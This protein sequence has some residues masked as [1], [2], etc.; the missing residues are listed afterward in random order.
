MVQRDQFPEDVM[1]IELWKLHLDAL[2]SANYVDAMLDSDGNNIDYLNTVGHGIQPDGDIFQER[3]DGFVDAYTGQLAIDEE[4]TVTD[5]FIDSDGWGTIEVFVSADNPSAIEGL[6]V[7]Y[8]DDAQGAQTVQG[9]ELRTFSGDD[10]DEGFDVF[11]FDTELDG[12]RVRYQNNGLEVSNATIN[13]SMRTQVSFESASFVDKNSLGDQYVR[14]GTKSASDGVKIGAPTSL[15]GDLETIERRTLIDQS[16]SF[17]TSTMRDESES[18]GSGTIAGNPNDSGEIE[19]STGATADSTINLRT[20]A[21]GRYTPG[22]SAQAGMG[23]RLI[24]T[25]WNEG[26]ATWGYFGD[27][28]DNGSGFQFGYDPVEDSLFIA[29]L[30]NGVEVER[31][32]RSNWNGQ[33]FE[34]VYDKPLDPTEGYIYQ[35]DYSW[36][37][38][39]IVNFQIVAQTIDTPSGLT[40]R[41]ETINVHSLSVEGDTT[42][43]D[44]NEP[45][46][47]ELE[48][49]ANGDDNRIAVGGRQFSVFGE[50]SEEKRITADT[51][52]DASVT[53]DTWTYVMSWQRDDALGNANAR[54]DFSS[55]DFSIDQTA[56]IALVLNAD[57]TGTTYNL[58]TLT[59]NNETLLEVSKAGTFNGIG[60]GRKVYEGSIFVSGTGQARAE[61]DIDAEVDFGQNGELTLIVQPQGGDGLVTETM[62]MEE[63]W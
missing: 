53:A 27:P 8:T 44:P 17:G 20:A 38:Y 39:G 5:G 57:V 13:V 11:R 49:G 14:I 32:Y 22:Y 26:E 19:L 7:D 4:V 35:I 37:G 36:Y 52:F 10:A 46:R 21:Y 3:A 6:K 59:P 42:I 23:I 30:D 60:A 25:P 33:D 51:R 29:L 48:N 61:L 41:Q 18:T 62:R 12:F 1:D 54:L 9:T 28:D 43:P 15:F 16:S 56:K 40:P 47:V 31:V 45:V 58:P 63:D 34:N 55:M 50:Q 24:D 2:Q